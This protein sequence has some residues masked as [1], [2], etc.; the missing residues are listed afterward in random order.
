[1]ALVI[2]G[3]TSFS[4]AAIS[5]LAVAGVSCGS[6]PHHTIDTELAACLPAD[7]LVAA[8]VNLEQLRQ[9]PLY[10]KLPANARAIAE[11]FGRATYLLLAFNGKE[12]ITAARG[13][14]QGNAPAGTTLLSANVAI[15]GSHQACSGGP[16]DLLAQ[17]ESVAAGHAIWMIA[18]GTA[19]LPLTGNAQNINRLLHMTDTLSLGADLHSGLALASTA[20]C[21]TPDAARGFE[22]SLRALLSLTAAG[23]RLRQPELAALLDSATIERRDRTVHAALSAGLDTAAQLLNFFG[24]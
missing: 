18:R 11:P 19:T 9:S 20:Q 10:A 16:A 17:A 23:L 6:A 15:A 24:R 3:R 4:L 7:T 21:R 8:G 2:P 13:D 5:A 12:L 22:E 1:M 14:F